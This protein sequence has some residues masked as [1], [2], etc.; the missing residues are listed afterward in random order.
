[1]RIVMMGCTEY[2]KVSQVETF[3]TLSPSFLL[4]LYF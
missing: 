1:M 4:F 2:L 3:Y